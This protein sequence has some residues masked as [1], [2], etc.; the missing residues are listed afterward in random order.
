MRLSR[1]RFLIIG[2]VILSAGVMTLFEL[3]I[4][5]QPPGSAVPDVIVGDIPDIHRWGSLGDETAFSIATTSCN[6]GNAPLRWEREPSKFH[7]VITQNLYRVHEGRIEQI[8][9]SWLKHGFS[10]FA[11]NECGICE[12]P[13]ATRFL[14]VNCSDP[15]TAGLNGTFRNLGPRSEVNAATGN[16]AIPFRR[17]SSPRTL[18]DGRIRVRNDDLDPTQ[19]VGARY[20]VESQYVHVQDTQAG[21]G[22]NNASHRETFVDVMSTGRFDLE[23]KSTFT[24]AREEPAIVSWRNVHSDVQ[25]AGPVDIPDDGRVL[26]AW[27]TTPLVVGGFRTTIAVENLTSHRS[28]RSVKATF[29][30]APSNPGFHDVDYQHEPYSSTDWTTNINVSSIEWQTETF[31]R[32]ENANA[33]RWGTLYTYWCDSPSRPTKIELG[34]FRGPETTITVDTSGT[35]TPLAAVAAPTNWTSV[36]S[37]VDIGT[38]KVGEPATFH[39]AC[40]KGLERTIAAVQG[41]DPNVKAA[42]APVEGYYGSR[43]QIRIQATKEAPA[44]HFES[45][46]TVTTD[47]ESDEQVRIRV[48]G[49]VED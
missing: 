25:L 29:T 32:N 24:I 49:S 41:S 18:L 12:A 20:F 43:W 9:M 35:I 3:R 47:K 27:R 15:Y 23:L 34:L 42:V 16:F 14:G 11:Q 6:I 21:T 46:L 4:A 33:L 26:V 8:G 10:V 7:P 5:A 37:S 30:G 31:A 19:N 45:V 36:P 2:T 48:F 17:L 1:V 13:F 39:I 40:R 28:V 38:L 44:G 22:N